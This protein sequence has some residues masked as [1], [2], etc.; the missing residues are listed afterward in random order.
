GD[1]PL[2][3]RLVVQGEPEHRERAH[4][5][6]E[7]GE[8]LVVALSRDDARSG[9]EEAHVARERGSSN[10]IGVR[11]SHGSTLAN[12]CIQQPLTFSSI[13]DGMGRDLQIDTESENAMTL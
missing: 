8:R 4:L 5:E 2:R 1:L 13:R 7:R 6:A 11:G 9:E 12:S 10:D 3:R